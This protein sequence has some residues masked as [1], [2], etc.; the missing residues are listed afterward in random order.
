MYGYEIPVNENA[1]AARERYLNDKK[2]AENAMKL[3]REY[4]EFI[5]NS[6]DYFLSEAMNM[7]LQKSLNENTS[8]E[9]REYGK[10]LIEGFV[11]ENTS[12]KLLTEFGKKTLLLAGIADVVKEAHQKVIHSCKEGDSKTFKI[13]KSINDE[14]FDKLIGLSDEKITEKINQRV[15]DSL[16]NYVQSN[17]NDKQNLEELAEK[18]AE[19]IN[20]IKARNAEEKDKIMKEFTNQYNKQVY[21]IK[22]RANRKVGVYEQL[23]HSVT[24]GIVSEQNILESFTEESGKLDMSKIRN[25]V[26]VMYTFL[27]M[28]NT[29]KM[30]NVNEAYLEN[31]IK[32]I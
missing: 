6:R 27:E 29:T 24:R 20:N 32:N 21:E 17:V 9:D 25:K 4:S 15:C 2:Q 31:I 18:T 16:E 5:T 10:A 3:K 23:V 14:F 26:T 8:S 7:I 11:K 28:L 19:K 22:Q 12:L 30:A 13:T 1:Y